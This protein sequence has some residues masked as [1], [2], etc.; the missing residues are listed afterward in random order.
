[1]KHCFA[2][3]VAAIAVLF[4]VAV[5]TAQQ[6]QSPSAKDN[7][8]ATRNS[9]SKESPSSPSVVKVQTE[10]ADAN[11]ANEVPAKWYKRPEWWAAVAAIMTFTI[12][13]WQSYET[14]RAATASWKNTDSMK[15]QIAIMQRQTAIAR[16]SVSA[17][18]NSERAWLLPVDFVLPRALSEVDPTRP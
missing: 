1:M 9:S 12:V 16:D 11:R 2:K 4:I 3:S 6:I 8:S 5:T 15:D 7:K 14:R 18:I 10:F 13:V 17:L